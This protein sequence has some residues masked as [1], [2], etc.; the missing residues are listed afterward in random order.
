MAFVWWPATA[1]AC[2]GGRL[3]LNFLRFWRLALPCWNTTVVSC[4]DA[5]AGLQVA[6]AETAGLCRW[7]LSRAPS[8]DILM[9]GSADSPRYV[10][11][12]CDKF[13]HTC[14]AIMTLL[15]ALVTRQTS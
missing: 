8:L 5:T 4:R 13:G 9:P 10:V 12:Y 1:V 7:L 2:R 6:E 14:T 3:L 11:L 15:R